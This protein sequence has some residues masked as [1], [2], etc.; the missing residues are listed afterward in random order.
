MLVNLNARRT[1]DG[2]VFAQ[3]QEDG[4]AKDKAFLSWEAFADWLKEKV[5]A[6]HQ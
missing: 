1:T 2:E 6:S 5:N 3:Y 4:K